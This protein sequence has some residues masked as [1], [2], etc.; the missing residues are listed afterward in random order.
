MNNTLSIFTSPEGED[1][2]DEAYN[3][4]FALWPVPHE[5]LDVDTRFGRTHINVSGPKDAPPLVLLHAAG[6]SSIAWFANIGAL[7]QIRRAYAVDIIGDAGKSRISR[8]LKSGEDHAD[9]LNDVLDGLAVDHADMLGHSQGGWMALALPLKY[10]NR[11]NKLIL[12]APAA[13]IHPFAWY[14]KLNLAL[15]RRMI[16]P[17]ARSQ[18]KF[19]AAKGANI[20]ERFVQFMEIVNSHCLPLTMVPGEYSDD[21]LRRIDM[22]TLL[23]IG[24]GEKIY[25]PHQAIERAERLMSDLTAEIIPNCSHLLIMEQPE[26]VNDRVLRFLKEPD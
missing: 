1:R 26:I 12:L 11:V 13:S 15:A 16:R 19:S 14:V 24:D 21:E 10:P 3:N 6:F 5:V 22:P 20:E 2:F 4:M 25:N 7:S 9:W 17:S 8:Q 23:L 18:L